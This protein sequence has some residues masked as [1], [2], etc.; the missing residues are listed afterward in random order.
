MCKTEQDEPGGQSGW[1]SFLNSL[2]LTSLIDDSSWRSGYGLAN[3]FVDWRNSSRL[4][5]FTSS[6]ANSVAQTH[7]QKSKS[8]AS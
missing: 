2:L 7:N 6:G 1:R 8:T 4:G 3:R 5:C